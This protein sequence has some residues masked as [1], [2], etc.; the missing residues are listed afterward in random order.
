MLIQFLSDCSQEFVFCL[1][2]FNYTISKHSFL[3]V[4]H[5]GV[6]AIFEFYRFIFFPKFGKFSAVFLSVPFHLVLLSLF[7][8][9]YYDT[10]I[11]SFITVS[12]ASKTFFSLNIF[13]LLFRLGK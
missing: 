7:S 12:Q 13:F 10:S 11:S 5:F 2:K 3:W 9:D 1:Q 4:Y 8:W 6:H